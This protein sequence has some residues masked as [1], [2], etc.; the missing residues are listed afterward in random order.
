MFTY[1]WN[2]CLTLSPL[3]IIKYLEIFV[4]IYTYSVLNSLK[5]DVWSHHCTVTLCSCLQWPLGCKTQWPFL[6]SFYFT[7]L[8]YLMKVTSASLWK[9]HPLIFK[10]TSRT[11][12]PS[13]FLPVSSSVSFAS[14]LHLTPWSYSI[15]S[16][17]GSRLLF[18]PTF[19]LLL[20]LFRVMLMSLDA[21]NNQAPLLNSQCTYNFHR[22]SN[23][24]ASQTLHIQMWKP[25][26]YFKLVLL[27]F[28]EY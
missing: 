12:D 2:Y 24:W 10:L 1:P 23:W 9:P 14:T 5:S 7:S 20:N 25:D 22:L 15:I 6:G 18:R 26:F 21:Q 17:L 16:V 11:L 28:C 8:Q 19:T 27:H 4:Y 3:F 13:K